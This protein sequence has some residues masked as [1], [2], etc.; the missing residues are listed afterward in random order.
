MIGSGMGKIYILESRRWLNA[1]KGQL[2]FSSDIIL[3]FD[4]AVKHEVENQGGIAYFVDSLCDQKEMQVNNFRATEFFKKWHLDSS[5][6]DIFFAQGVPFGFS[7][8]IEI[9]SEY[10]FYVRLRANLDKLAQFDAEDIYIGEDKG[11]IGD[12]LSE[13]GLPFTKL[14]RPEKKQYPEYFFDIHEYMQDALHRKSIKS[15][16]RDSLVKILSYSRYYLDRFF[17]GN[18]TPR[19]VFVQNYHPTKKI[20]QQLQKDSDIRVITPSL[21]ASQGLKKYFVQRMIPIRSTKNKFRKQSESMLN[22]FKTNRSASLYLAS[23]VDITSGAYNV[24]EKKINPIVPEA[25]QILYSVIKYVNHQ[26]IHL[27][28]MIANIGLLQTIVDCVLKTKQ[29]PSYF[30]INGLLSHDYCDEGCYATVINSY[31]ESIKEHYFKGAENVVCLGDPR[32]DAYISQTKRHSIERI[33]PA[34]SIGAS[35]F[36]NTDLNSY[37]AV[38]FDFIFDILSTFNDLKSEGVSF[39]LQIKVRPNGVLNQYQTFVKEFFPDLAIEIVRE[40]TMAE[41]FD[42]TDLYISLYSQTLFEASCLGIPVIYYK[43]D[44]EI[45]GPPFDQ[46]SELVTVDSIESLK[47]A[48]VDFQSEHQRFEPFLEKSVM[49]KYVGH[50]DG[51]NLDRNL[52]YIRN[53]LNTTTLK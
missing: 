52:D 2:D 10:L 30:I 39:K 35:G 15:A 8:R 50:L 28:V 3:T 5:G 42:K 20:L 23:G 47:K 22:D 12:I 32:M 27:Q 25:L 29:V 45:M 33:T 14:L 21:V 4:F 7:F 6:N 11:F 48:F 34:I 49:E 1:L 51:K 41:V 18:H 38:E 53:L 13:M 43:K 26:P 19:S 24:I 31:S 17:S 16:A 9:W 46:K 44:K 37:V 40:V 36:N